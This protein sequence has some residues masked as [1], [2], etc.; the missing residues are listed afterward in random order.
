MRLGIDFAT[1][2]LRV[3]PR[4]TAGAAMSDADATNPWS[5]GRLPIVLLIVLFPPCPL[6][7]YAS[8]RL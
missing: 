5:T 8:G 7:A 4:S 2:S 1:V 3:A 6:L